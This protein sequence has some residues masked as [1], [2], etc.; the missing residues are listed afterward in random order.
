MEWFQQPAAEQHD[1]VNGFCEPRSPQTSDDVRWAP[2]EGESGGSDSCGG[3]SVSELTELQE[4]KARESEDEEVKK[5]KEVVVPASKV[6]KGDKKKKEKEDQEEESKQNSSAAPSYT[7]EADLR[8]GLSWP[9]MSHIGPI[10]VKKMNVRL[11][12]AASKISNEYYNKS[13]ILF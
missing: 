5:E 3:A 2:A 4:L 9:N 13:S 6:P 12:E 10:S 8:I 7:G 1:G 11:Y